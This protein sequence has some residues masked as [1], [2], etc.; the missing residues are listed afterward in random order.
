M[1]KSK[2]IDDCKNDKIYKYDF[3]N[4][5]YRECPNETF[6]NETD[7][8]CYQIKNIETTIV[9]EIHKSTD[10]IK[11]E[12]DKELDNFREIISDLNVSEKKK[13]I[14]TTKDNIQ[15]HSVTS[16]K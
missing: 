2:C 11:E 4:I 15:F 7:Y 13:D 6:Q 10:I 12:R 9:N 16:F 3:N 1:N 14:I 8:I 5:C